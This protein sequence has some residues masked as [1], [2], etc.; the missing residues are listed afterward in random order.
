MKRLQHRSWPK[1]LPHDVPK[2]TT[3]LYQ[4]FA[5]S[6]TKNPQKDCV[7]FYGKTLSYKA[8]HDQIL[9]ISAYLRSTC[10]VK[11]GDRVAIYAQNCPQYLLTLY[12]ILRAGAVVVPI[13]PMNLTDEVKYILN[14]AQIDV[15]F[16]AQ[17]RNDQ[18]APLLDSADLSHAISIIYS[19]FLSDDLDMDVPEI[20]S[21]AACPLP[22]KFTAWT[23]AT[24]CDAPLPTYDREP[25]DLAILP[26]TSGSTGRGK[27]CMHTN[28]TALHAARAVYEWFGFTGRDSF[29]S[30]SPMFH[31]VGLQ[32]GLLTPVVIGATTV[33]LPRWDKKVATQLIRDY[34]VTV[35]PTVPTMV[36]D[37]VNQTDLERDDVASLHTV[38]G[39]GIAM[40]DAVAERLFE[41]T[42]LTFLEGY[43][44]TETIAPS[45]ANPRDN[46]KRQCGGLPVFNTDIVIVDPDTLQR[47]PTDDVGEILISGPQVMTGYWNNEEANAEAF[48]EIEGL[49]FL[50]T[51]DLG[52]MDADGYVFIVDRL[53][54]MINASGYKVWPTEVEATLYSHPDIAEA[55]II[56]SPDPYRGETV[57]ALIVLREG[58]KTTGEDITKWAYKHMAPYKVPRIVE[59]VDS[60]MK[61]GSGKVL[62]RELQ[63]IENEKS[64]AEKAKS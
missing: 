31:V 60:L 35:W 3:T 50:R 47:V 52:R 62:W 61:S 1:G 55:C 44:L 56:S 43:G 39:G 13:N 9:R 59:F 63:I 37:F 53:K 42:N 45:T 57:K 36:I 33:I 27:G 19:D 17:D 32:C 25:D 22:G 7:N 24:Q 49:R 40:P 21:Q 2:T 54:R 18:I 48:S 23:E 16:V 34:K 10:G 20:I 58:A 38:F 64:K 14:D 29:L 5:D 15:I 46:P 28:A 41:L 8:A 11:P 30:V 4:T 6:T 51:G 26:Y 12:G